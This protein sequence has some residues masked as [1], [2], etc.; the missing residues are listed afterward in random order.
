M[1]SGATTF[2]VDEIWLTRPKNDCRSFLL[3]GAGNCEIA[4]VIE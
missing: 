2:V 3:V 4:S 1:S